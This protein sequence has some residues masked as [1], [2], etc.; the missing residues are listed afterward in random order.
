MSA[1]PI[2]ESVSPSVPNDEPAGVPY[3][4]WRCYDVEVKMGEGLAVPWREQDL[5]ALVAQ[6]LPEDAVADVATLR[7]QG[8]LGGLSRVN[9]PLAPQGWQLDPIREQGQV[10]GVVR[11]RMSLAALGG[12]NGELDKGRKR[13]HANGDR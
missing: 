7:E 12:T 5:L 2:A 3:H 6:A 13:H 4:T 8:L 9:T 11:R 1:V 10:V